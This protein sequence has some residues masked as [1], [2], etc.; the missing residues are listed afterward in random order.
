MDNGIHLDIASCKYS[1]SNQSMSETSNNQ[2]PYLKTDNKKLLTI[3]DNIN[4]SD[5]TSL[6]DSSVIQRKLLV[7]LNKND[8]DVCE[9]LENSVSQLR[10]LII[11]LN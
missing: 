11:K 3:H 7:N 2:E 6:S 1:I 5:T 4:C 10:Y 8:T 9:K